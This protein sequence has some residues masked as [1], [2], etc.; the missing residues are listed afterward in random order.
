MNF[1]FHAR[2]IETLVDID[3]SLEKDD[4]SGMIAVLLEEIVDDSEVVHVDESV[5]LEHFD[6]LLKDEDVIAFVEG[7]LDVQVNLR[8]FAI[9][10]FVLITVETLTKLELFD[11]DL[12]GLE[13]LKVSILKIAFHRHHFDCLAFVVLG[14]WRTLDILNGVEHFHI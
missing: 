1:D 10:D 13:F 2:F 5:E 4:F 9:S 3:K 11:L 7:R 12:D 14:Q 6:F 8:Y